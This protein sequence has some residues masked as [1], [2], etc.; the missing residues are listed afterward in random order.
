METRSLSIA[1]R[2]ALP[3]PAVISLRVQ[4]L[5]LT[6]VKATAPIAFCAGSVLVAIL[7]LIRY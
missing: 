3:A 4:T 5:F 7:P 1:L 2:K 6:N